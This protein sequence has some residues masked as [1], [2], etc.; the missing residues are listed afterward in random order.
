MLEDV[1]NNVNNNISTGDAR[2]NSSDIKR[3]PSFRAT[4]PNAVDTTPTADTY[5]Q[6]A[7]ELSPEMGMGEKYI[8]YG[9]PAGAGL[10][11]LSELF[12][13]ANQGEYEKSLLGRLGRFGDYLSGTSLMNNRFVD[14]A[15]DK[16]SKGK[17][18]GQAFIDR[19]EI[20]SAMQ[21]TPTRPTC[22]LVTDFLQTQN[23]SDLKHGVS[24][25][26]DYF[27]KNP[28]TLKLAGASEAEINAL[29][30]K[31]GTGLFGR[32][33]NESKAVEEFLINKIGTDIGDTNILSRIEAR[34]STLARQLERYQTALEKG[35]I[36]GQPLNDANKKWL[37]SRI[38]SIKKLQGE[39]RQSALR[40][41]KFK[42]MNLNQRTLEAMVKEPAKYAQ[43]IENG[44][45]N[46][47]R[48]SPKMSEFYNKVRS[49]T[50]PTTKLGKLLPKAAKLGMRGLTFGGGFINCLLML[51]FF[52]G[53]AVK[54]TID[55][56]KDQKV[57]TGVHGLFDAISW[58][59]AMPLAVKAMHAM[60]GLKN[61]GK[62]E[63]QV[64]AYEDAYKAFKKKNDAF[65]FASKAEHEAEW[66]AVQRLKNAGTKPK[67][68][69]W[70][71][72]KIAT[73]T[74]IGLGQKPQYKE[75]TAPLNWGLNIKNV[76][77]PDNLKKVGGNLARLSKNFPKNWIG[78]PL[79]FALYAFAFQP[80]VD[81]LFTTPLK[82]VF[83]KP[84]EPDEI[85]EEME[86][87]QQEAEL[88]ALRKRYLYPGPSISPNPEAVKGVG[89]LDPNMLADDNL[90]KQE[91]IK[92]GLATP[93]QKFNTIN[94]DNGYMNSANGV[95]IDIRNSN[96]PFMPAD[97][98]N[99]NSTRTNN[100]TF[101]PDPNKSD[102][103][104]VSRSFVPQINKENPVPYS[105]PFTNPN[106]ERNYDKMRESIEK[107]EK[108]IAETEKWIDNKFEDL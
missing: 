12:N 17:T 23:E 64:K 80:I 29:K 52:L 1:K 32:I 87:K 86:K 76:L 89:E 27:G 48:Y 42:S 34:E 28:R 95:Q 50:A 25:L 24:K 66:Q 54:N 90:V 55:A 100:N 72:S 70:V 104:T 56:P 45:E 68:I 75:R 49:A 53:D 77:K 2:I 51:G 84:Y 10:Y 93:S 33:S 36:N 61:L 81:K 59:V 83:G 65:G 15:K 74:S 62:T 43:N 71:L 9:V 60:N 46:A 91:L 67:G 31:Y 85:R 4:N 96:K 82:A 18:R 8:R 21:K 88:E 41:L 19:H 94:Q 39:Y 3:V 108:F 13:K 14:W 97:A 57:A 69:K 7:Q 73:F 40:S 105:D 38:S 58:V 79:R 16:V 102:Y 30:T 101:T 63:A 103:D 106:Y 6:N 37:E 20:L 99:Q 78:Y 5:S 35:T 11:V 98:V 22:P 92:R 107:S 26:K 47:S 44:L